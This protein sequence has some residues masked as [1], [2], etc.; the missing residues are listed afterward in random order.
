MFTDILIEDSS[1]ERAHRRF[2]ALASFTLQAMTVSFLMLV[3]LFHSE[4]L[5]LLLSSESPLLV[6]VPPPGPPPAVERLHP[7]NAS[8]SNLIAGQVVLPSLIPRTVAIVD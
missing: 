2:T 6:P 4:S 1:R 7:A 8:V 5:P 3:P